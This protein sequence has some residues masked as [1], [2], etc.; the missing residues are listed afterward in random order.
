MKY[1]KIFEPPL[2]LIE[3][4]GMENLPIIEKIS[5]LMKKINLI[6]EIRNILIPRLILGL[7]KI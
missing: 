6:K 2:E 3:K 4:F 7:I 1:I 5:I